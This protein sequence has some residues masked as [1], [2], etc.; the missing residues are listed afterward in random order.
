MENPKYKYRRLEMLINKK[1]QKLEKSKQKIK[2][3]ISILN[4]QTCSFSGPRPQNLPWGFNEDDSRCLEMKN[5]LKINIVS[6][7]EKGFKIFIS[8]MALGF[9]MICAKM[10]LELKKIY[11]FIKLIGAIP[12]K[13]QDKFWNEKDKQRYRTLLS[14]LDGIRCIY[15]NYIGSECMFERNR[16]MVNNS[17]LLITYFNGKS[18][19]TKRTVDYAEKQGINI[20]NLYSEEKHKKIPKI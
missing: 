20:I 6:A 4:S 14:Q 18:G 9:D 8:G 19:G 7:I 2:K 5:N 13:T 11:P 3:F 16:Y 10:V 17:S 1:K 15:D 12:C